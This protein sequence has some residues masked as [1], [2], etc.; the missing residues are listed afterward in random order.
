[1]IRAASLS[2][3]VN[4]LGFSELLQRQGVPHRIIE[5]SGQQVIWVNGEQEAAFVERA[6]ADWSSNSAM[7][8]ASLDSQDNG[9]LAGGVALLS[10]HNLLRPLRLA[11]VNSPVTLSL[12]A[13]CLLVALL[14]LMGTQTARVV[15]LFYPLLAADNLFALLAELGDIRTICAR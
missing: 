9:L 4:L 14:S 7:Q 3:N 10:R 12:I 13:A 11:F 6:L 2:I 5:E 15:F 1:M 8:Q